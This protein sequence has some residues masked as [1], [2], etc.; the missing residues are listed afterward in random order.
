MDG[1]I[2]IQTVEETAKRILFGLHRMS[3]EDGLDDSEYIR[4]VKNVLAETKRYIS[5]NQDISSYSDK[6]FQSLYDYAKELW[7]LNI[8]KIR[9]KTVGSDEEDYVLSDE[10]YDEYYYD[11]LYNYSVFPG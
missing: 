5:D 6:I 11:Y 4:I 8:E 10:G 7:L 1:T 2:I 3:I 9:E